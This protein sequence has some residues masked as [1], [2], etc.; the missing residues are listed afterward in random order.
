MKRNSMFKAFGSD[1]SIILFLELW[2]N[3]KSLIRFDLPGLANQSVNQKSN[4]L[5]VYS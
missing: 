5:N 1:A 3:V 2:R 4:R